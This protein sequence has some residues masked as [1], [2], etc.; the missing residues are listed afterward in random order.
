M[1]LITEQIATLLKKIAPQRVKA[2]NKGHSHL[3]A[4]D[5][6]AHLNR[7]FGFGG[8]DKTILALDI[9]HERSTEPQLKRKQKASDPD[10]FDQG[11][12]WV[13]YSCRMRLTIKDPVGNKVATYEDAATGSAQNMPSP[14]DAYDFAIKNAVSYALKRCAKDLGDQFGLSLYNKG[15]TD[16]LVRNTL[17]G[18]PANG[19]VPSD[20][21]L[22]EGIPT[23]ASLGNDERHYDEDDPE[24]P[25]TDRPQLETLPL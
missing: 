11:R 14:A 12:W 7:V 1:S 23:P 25:F 19:K 16:A 24:R 8:W 18:K 21:D 5:V 10:E 2:D 13:T 17:I 9:V 20:T 22:Q 6:I 15:M 3:P 4:Y